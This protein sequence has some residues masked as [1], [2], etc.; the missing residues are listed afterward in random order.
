MEILGFILKWGSAWLLVLVVFF[1]WIAIARKGKNYFECDICGRVKNAEI[2]DCFPPG[3]GAVLYPPDQ[4]GDIWGIAC[5]ECFDKGTVNDLLDAL[6][7]P[8]G[9]K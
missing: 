8:W 7:H 4:G 5:K 1:S 3:W 9:M 6:T 2:D